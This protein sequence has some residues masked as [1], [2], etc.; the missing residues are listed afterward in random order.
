MPE[1]QSILHKSI[2]PNFEIVAAGSH[3]KHNNPVR[4]ARLVAI[5]VLAAHAATHGGKGDQVLDLDDVPV[6]EMFGCGGG[7]SLRDGS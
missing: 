3:K 6:H 7:G 4:K 5:P 1:G 2:F